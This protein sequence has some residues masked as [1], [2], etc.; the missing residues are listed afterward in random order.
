MAPHHVVLAT[1]PSGQA[2]DIVGPADVFAAANALG[3]TPAYRVTFASA[4][5]DE[6]TLSNG[7]NIRTRRLSTI[8]TTIDTLIVGGAFHVAPES[9]PLTAIVRR[10]QEA[11]TRMASVCTGA[12]ILAEAG[13]FDG[14]SA[15][16]HW[17]ACQ[18][19]ARKYPAITVV[20]DRIHVRDGNVWS[21]AGVTA[22]M[23][24]ALAMVTDDHGPQVAREIAR[25]LVIYL[26]RPGGQSQFSHHY[27]ATT[28]E[29]ALAPALDWIAANLA[30]DCSVEHI[31]QQVSMSARHL[32]RLFAE[33]LSL[34]PA[35]YVHLHRLHEAKSLLETTVLDVATVAK[36]CGFARPETFHRGFRQQFGV[37]PAQ[38][39]HLFAG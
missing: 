37:T 21:S 30:G 24:L 23:D 25:W 14:R 13:L 31:A 17:S 9:D 19:L 6:I 22:G 29:A 20:E 12:F 28:P 33:Q 8:R 10:R 15:T 39:R 38:H 16:T 11:T 32:S 36:R 3:V 2:L 35:R 34:S 7:L 1:G 26:Q 18:R 27:Q 4:T 5:A